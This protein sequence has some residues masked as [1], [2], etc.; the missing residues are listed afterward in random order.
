M[1]IFTPYPFDCA[2]ISSVPDREG[3]SAIV[4]RKH[5]LVVCGGRNNGDN[6][7]TSETEN[8]EVLSTK[9]SVMR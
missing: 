6:G 1:K 8:D 9:C 4:H 7:T 3:A 2:N 5:T